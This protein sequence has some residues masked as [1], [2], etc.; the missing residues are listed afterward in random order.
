LAEATQPTNEKPLTLAGKG[1]VVEVAL[2]E[3]VVD[4]ELADTGTGEDDAA[5]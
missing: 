3:E 5:T 1:E 2:F 4:V